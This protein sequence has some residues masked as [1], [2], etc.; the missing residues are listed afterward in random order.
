MLLGVETNLDR[1]VGLVSKANGN[2]EWNAILLLPIE[3]QNRIVDQCRQLKTQ[4]EQKIKEVID[5]V[6]GKNAQPDNQ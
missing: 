5:G 3:S 1:E 4:M 6:W 2:L